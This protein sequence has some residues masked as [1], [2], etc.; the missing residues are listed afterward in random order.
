MFYSPFSSFLLTEMEPAP[1]RTYNR[2]DFTLEQE[3]KLIEHVKS[4]PALYN[5]K[6][7]LYK[8]RTYRDRIWEDFGVTI[9]KS[10]E[11]HQTH[12]MIF[13]NFIVF[14]PYSKVLTA[15]KNG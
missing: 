10:G 4:N 9:G 12:Q 11:L 14:S 1:K 6:D 2:L 15:T 13:C 7:S 3:E 5:P 8:S